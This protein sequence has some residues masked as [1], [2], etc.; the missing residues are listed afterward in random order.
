VGKSQKHDKDYGTTYETS[1]RKDRD[2]DTC[3]RDYEGRNSMF[4]ESNCS[5][6]KNKKKR[7]ETHVSRG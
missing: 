4:G 6:K 5:L 7:R 3:D 1:E 2:K